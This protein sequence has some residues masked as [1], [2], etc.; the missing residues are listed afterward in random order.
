V[1]KQAGI[2]GSQLGTNWVVGAMT[3]TLG[4]AFYHKKHHSGAFMRPNAVHCHGF[5]IFVL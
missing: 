1:W 4:G 2:A 3:D 5:Y